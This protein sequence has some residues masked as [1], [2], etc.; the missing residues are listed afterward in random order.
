LAGEFTGPIGKNLLKIMEKR[1]RGHIQ[2]LAK[3]LG[4]SIISGTVKPR[5]SDLAHTFKGS[6]QTKAH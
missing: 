4:A 2:G 1:E 6:I 5:T 3:F